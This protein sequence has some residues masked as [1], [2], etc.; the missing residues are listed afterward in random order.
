MAG[1]YIHIPFCKQACTYC[2]FYFSTSL[3]Q[4]SPFIDSLLKEI[5]LNQRLIDKKENIDTIY[6][7]GGTPSL[8]TINELDHIL[9]T[10]NKNFKIIGSVEITLEA[11]PDDI[12]KNKLKAWMASG[13]NR[14]SLGVQSFNEAE[15]RWMNRAHNSEESL[16]SIDIILEAGMDNFSADLIFG[17]PILSN[18]A[19]EKNLQI[20]SKKNIPHLSCY[21]LTVEP[22][23]ALH[24]MIEAKKTLPIDNEAQAHQFLLVMNYLEAAGYEQYEISNYAKEGFRSKHNSSYWQGIPYYG[25]GPSAHSFNGKDKRRWNVANL[26][27]YIKTLSSGEIPYEE[28]SLTAEQQINEYIMIALRT[29]DGVDLELFSEKF[30]AARR[31]ALKKVANR[32]LQQ[33]QMEEINNRFVLTKQGKLF[34][35]HIAAELFF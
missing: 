28:E 8:L 3:K 21:G 2:N 25:F 7:G 10:L 11:N 20:I 32:F 31:E 29:I 23:T 9:E 30:G 22:R 1:I 34:A 15:L 16:R 18:E 35:D 13:I 19:L 12:E 24:K 33:Q 17:S 5:A 14:L 6:F 27:T 4:K 26:A